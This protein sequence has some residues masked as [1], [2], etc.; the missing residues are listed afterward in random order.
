MARTPSAAI[1]WARSIKTW[2]VGMCANFWGRAYG[3]TFTGYNDAIT[4][5][6]ATPPQ[7]R[8]PGD[9]TAPLGGLYYFSGGSAKHGHVSG[10]IGS[11]DATISTDWPHSGDVSGT[12][13]GD[14][15]RG[16]GL[17]PLGW[18][19]PF[20]QGKL[21]AD[22]RDQAVT[23]APSLPSVSLSRL[24]VACAKQNG[25]YAAGTL[26]VARALHE[27]GYLDAAHVDGVFGWRKK[28]A[29]ASLQRRLGYSGKDA[30]GMPGMTSLAWLGSHYKFH[31]VR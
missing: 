13:V 22:L 24:Q 23:P 11:R 20:Y 4:Q 15:E 8:H 28:R 5:W 18:A 17:H 19:S 26:I 2:A 25:S 31:A 12:T 14:I 10:G 6:Y 9:L 21:V 27:L 1:A 30:N 16:W 29:Y 7:Y 3:F